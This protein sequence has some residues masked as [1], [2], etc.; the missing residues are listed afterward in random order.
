MGILN[1][2]LELYIIA[3]VIRVVIS[4]VN[5]GLYNQFTEILYKITDPPL[6]MIRQFLPEMGGLDLSPM[7][8]IL[9]I[10]LL[11]RLLMGF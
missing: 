7:V 3:I 11:Q 2:L 10:I 8:L 1:L 5:P 6:A 4:W 9:L